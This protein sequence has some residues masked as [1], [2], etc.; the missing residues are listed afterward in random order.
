MINLFP[1]RI[2]LRYFYAKKQER[3]VTFIS[4]VSMIGV[5]IGVA[6]LIV[7]M[8][9]M[10]GFHTELSRNIIGLG[11]DINIYS[12]QRDIQ[13]VDSVISELK[14][15]PYI[16]KAIPLINGQGLISGSRNSSG[17][18]VR[19]ISLEDL[20]AMPQVTNNILMGNLVEFYNKNSIIIGTELAAIIGTRVGDKV[21]IIS[22][23]TV[24]TLMG[25]MPRAK[26]FNVVGVYQSGFYEYDSSVVF[27]N[28]HSARTF[29]SVDKDNASALQVITNDPTHAKEL[30][31][32]I[33]DDLQNAYRVVSWQSQNEQFLNALTVE[34]SAMFTILSLII[35][36]AAFNIVSSQFMLVRDKTKDIAILL[37][38][39]ATP[40]MIRTIFMINGSIIGLIGTGLGVLLG[41]SFALNIDSI[42]SWL[43]SIAGITLFDNAIYFLS[44]LPS[45][46]EMMDIILVSSV[47]VLLCFIATLYP[48]SRAANLKPVEA[49]RYE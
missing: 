26:S 2:A 38:M 16:R 6:A 7:V 22:N 4:A 8:A 44:Y 36:V 41:V 15:K 27:M 13:Q 19:G 49:L 25:T 14:Q 20:D 18:A 5:M 3:L 17:I 34:R 23:N 46:L 29:L 45:E 21:R 30:A 39:G 35:I 48:A 43:E 9:V 32:A 28:I 31:L 12:Y 11:G 10:N 47:S 42:K 40:N 1:F 33:E 37:T 24:S